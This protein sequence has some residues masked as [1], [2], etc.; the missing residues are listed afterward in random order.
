MHHHAAIVAGLVCSKFS[1]LTYEIEPGLFT[2][3]T[4]KNGDI[5][6]FEDPNTT[7]S[8]HLDKIMSGDFDAPMVQDPF[9][10]SAYIPK[11]DMN[12]AE[13]IE[14]ARLQSVWISNFKI[15]LASTSIS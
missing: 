13:L 10:L 15:T 3:K 9:H 1:H 8:E 6:S 2:L 4:L 5:K 11:S 14:G 7:V 12:V